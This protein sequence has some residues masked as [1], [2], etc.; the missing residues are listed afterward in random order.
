MRQ[1]S[2]H[3]TPGRF[4]LHLQKTRHIIEYDHVIKGFIRRLRQTHASAC[5]KSR[6]AE[7]ASAQFDL[8]SPLLAARCETS[9]DIIEEGSGDTVLPNEV[10]QRL[11]NHC[12]EVDSEYR[13]GS[14][15]GSLQDQLSIDGDDAGGQ[16]RQDHRESLALSIDRLPTTLSLLSS[17]SQ[18]LGHI[19]ERLNEKAHFVVRTQRYARGEISFGHRA[20]T[21]H[22][23]LHRLEQ[24]FGRV[25]R[26]VNSAE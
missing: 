24:H 23:I 21:S 15:I 26:T 17:T 10:G 6:P 5:E 14:R 16:S 4:A 1:S 20:R 3:F 9:P 2:R 19:V 18:T 25:D 12:G 8:L 22:Q 11:A 13:V 7:A